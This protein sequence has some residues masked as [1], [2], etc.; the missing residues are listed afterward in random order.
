MA[1]L[2]L[3]FDSQILR[4]IPIGSRPVTIG[5]AP[6]NDV[7]IDNLA[8]SDHH[9]RLYAE[10]DRLV[11]ED[12]TSLNGTYVNDARIERTTLRDGDT[13]QIGKHQLQLDA[14]Q[15]AAAPAPGGGA[16][17]ALRKAPVPKIIET[18]VLDTEAQR[19]LLRQTD[20]AGPG[21]R[22]AGG[23]EAADAASPTSPLRHFATSDAGAGPGKLSPASPKR[24]RPATLSVLRGRTDKREYTLAGKL[25]VIG[26]S[27]MASVR[28]LGWFAPQVAGQINRRDDGY[29]LGL[30]DRIPKVNGQP[31]QG[32]TRLHD[33]DIIELGRVRLLFSSRD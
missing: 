20:A 21:P 9:A 18:A 7:H 2:L 16:A 23:G 30:G 33:G 4:E 14:A 32:P 28:L 5:R 12:L 11:L 27:E 19:N 8:V 24:Q 22:A 25:T 26:R 1:R 13:I 29:Y 31:I 6:D 15:D 17:A 3:K 10:G